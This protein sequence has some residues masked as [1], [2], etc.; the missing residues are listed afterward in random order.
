MNRQACRSFTFW[1]YS[2]FAIVLLI[3]KTANFQR[4][5]NNKYTKRLHNSVGC[6]YMLRG[7]GSTS[8]S[9]NQLTLSFLVMREKL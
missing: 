9:Y 4:N 3:Q 8:E 2:V 1:I 6:A 5:E 7:Y